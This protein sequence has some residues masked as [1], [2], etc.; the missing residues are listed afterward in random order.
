MKLIVYGK[1]RREFTTKSGELATYRRIFARKPV[2]Y[3]DQSNTKTNLFVG[4]ECNEYK[5]RDIAFKLLPDDLESYEG[6][7]VCN[8]DFDEKGYIVDINDY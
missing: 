3:C 4:S 8:V 2:E 6:G 1:V 7:L 5:V